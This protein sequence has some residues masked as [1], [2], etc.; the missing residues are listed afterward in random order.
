VGFKIIR[1]E[2]FSDTTFLM[3]IYAPEIAKKRKAG[4]FLI[5]RLHE[6]GERIPLTI[7]D[8]NVKKG[9]ITIVVQEIGK[10]TK[11]LGTFEEGDKILDIVGPLGNPTHIE[12]WGTVVCVGG[13]LGIAPLYPITETL[14]NAG[15]Y[16]ISILGARTKSLL[17]WEDRFKKISHKVIIA[18]DDGSYGIK[19]VV[20][21]P[22]E[23]ILKSKKIDYIYC[24]GPVIMMKFVTI[25]AKKYNVPIIVSLNPIMVD[26]TGMCG[27]CRVTI[28]DETKFACVDG[29]E[30][31]GYKVNF[32]ELI[33][34]LNYYKSEEKLALERFEKKHKCRCEGKK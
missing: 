6:K 15:N 34:R 23:N 30:F 12:K 10:T 16:V 17:F 27:C 18:T 11:E 3:E 1:K 8:A 4:Q 31:D 26:G 33:K 22:L 7:A 5:L 19:G 24:V 28:G 9:T 14:K 32:D 13:G 2:R 29:P 25:T 21:L 20:T